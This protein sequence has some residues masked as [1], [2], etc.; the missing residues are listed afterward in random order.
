MN[1]PAASAVD[2]NGAPAASRRETLWHKALWKLRRDRAGMAGL[3]VV[4]LYFL[5]AIGVWLG[6]WAT[7]WAEVAGGKWEAPSAAHWFGTN[8]I[9]QDIF[10]RSVY[11]ISTAFE[12]GLV[13]AVLATLLGGVL[14]ALAGFFAGRFTDELVVWLMGVLDSIPF[15]LLVAAIAFAMAGNPYAMHVAMISTFWITTARLV[16]GEVIKLRQLEFVEAAHAIGVPEY[17]IVFRHILP[18]TLHILLVQSTI[19]FVAAIKSEVILS[20]L[21]LG[22][23]DGMSWGLMI[24]ESTIEVLA[25]FFG[26][27]LAASLLMF[28]LVMAFNF[29]SDALQDALDPRQ[30]S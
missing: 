23:K 1:A 2:A 13:V 4:M 24:A 18:N 11:S 26:N 28:G 21:G 22:V 20:F 19:T 9:G 29:L 10:A 5:A 30:V 15:Y 16:R 12:V 14:G 25:G 8:L 7:G 17:T 3:A 6:W 27:F